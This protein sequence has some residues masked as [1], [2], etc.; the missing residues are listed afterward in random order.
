MLK[1]LIANRFS[2]GRA[3][4]QVFDAGAAKVEGEEGMQLVPRPGRAGLPIKLA[5]H[6]EEHRELAVQGNTG[7][8]QRR[9]MSV[10]SHVI[11]HLSAGLGLVHLP[12][13]SLA[14]TTGVQNAVCS[15][16]PRFVGW[17]PVRSH[18][19]IAGVAEIGAERLLGTAGQIVLCDGGQL[20]DGLSQSPAA[21]WAEVGSKPSVDVSPPDS[22]IDDGQPPYGD[23]D[24]NQSRI[25]CHG[26]NQGGNPGGVWRTPGQVAGREKLPAAIAE[27]SPLDRRLIGATGSH[28]AP[29]K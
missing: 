4:E 24:S 6:G 20:E 29:Y 21:S 22:E 3:D 14:V 13:H 17:D 28:Q 7:K 23:E 25:T 27:L 16:D 18:P 26:P 19:E 10:A 8:G 15:L 2:E 12:A 11:R 9:V 1:V 5:E